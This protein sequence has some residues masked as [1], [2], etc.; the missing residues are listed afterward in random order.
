MVKKEQNY[1]QVVFEWPLYKKH[2]QDHK[3]QQNNIIDS[4]RHLLINLCIK[5]KYFFLFPI[6]SVSE[7]LPNDSRPS[8]MNPK[9][10]TYKNNKNLGGQTRPS[11]RAV[12]PGAPLPPVPGIF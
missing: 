2:Y 11:Q 8:R 4:L 1:V 12:G 3:N 5:H 10:K 9:A 7:G 6:V